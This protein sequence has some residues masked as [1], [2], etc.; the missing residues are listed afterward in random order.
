MTN[1]TA[2]TALAGLAALISVACAAGDADHERTTVVRDSAGVRI[3]EN[4][5]DGGAWTGSELVSIGRLDGPAEYTFSRIAD[6]AAAPGGRVYVLDAGDNLVKVYDASGAFLTSF[7]GEGE[8]PAEFQRPAQV[9]VRGDTVVVYDFDAPKFAYFTADGELLRTER[10]DLTLLEY[11]FARLLAPVG[12]GYLAVAGIGCSFPPPEDRRPKWRLLSV[13]DDG[14]VRGLMAVRAQRTALAIYGD[15]FCRSSPWPPGAPNALAVRPDG[16]AA[17][18]TGETYEI[19]LFR[20]GADV[21]VDPD[22]DPEE[23]GLWT[24]PDPVGIIRRDADA[25][26]VTAAQIEAHRE[27]MIEQGIRDDETGTIDRDRL[28]AH[29]AAWDSAFVPDRWPAFVELH[30]DARGRLWAARGGPPDETTRSWDV[31]DEDGRLA[32]SVELPADLEVYAVGDTVW[33]VVRDE[34]DVQRVRAY[35]V[36][37]DDGT[38]S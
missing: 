32:A 7:G 28:E 13:G 10:S 25:P 26:P 16:L 36:A 22:A 31:F 12:D 18:G 33:G 30:W 17:F 38:G 2:L 5:A 1:R 9:T 27:E 34:L 20:L 14:T 11:G 4:A 35:R 23:I 8:G 21:D 24:L 29:E 37:A 6:M 19:R 3:V 15:R